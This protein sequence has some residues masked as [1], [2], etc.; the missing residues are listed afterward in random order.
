MPLT[1][2]LIRAIGLA[3]KVA[4]TAGTILAP[5]PEI[6]ARIE[7]LA[8]TVGPHGVDAFGFDPQ[9]VKKVVGLPLWLYRNYFRVQVK[10]VEHIPDGPCFVVANHS[11]QLPFD[12]AMLMTAAFL[13]REP[14]RY[15]RA[16]L[17]KFV[18]STP[19]VSVFLS[20]CGQVLGTP[21]NCRRLLAAGEAILVFPEGVRGLNKIW[22][23]RYRL[24][25]FGKGFMR[26]AIETAAPIVPAV[27]IGAEEQAPAF[28]KLERLGDLLGLPAVP[29]TPFHPMLPL[30]GLWPLPTRYRIE[31][32]EPV[33]FFGDAA[34][35]DAV[36][37]RVEEL[38][39][40][41]QE[42]IDAKLAAREHVFW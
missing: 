28:A 18:P 38:K 2:V 11:G 1:D 36:G 12:A 6:E 35:D 21:E 27:V 20:R 10:G 25:R 8:A 14:P 29:V 16:M 15:L 17:D 33:R 34:D 26:L 22:D 19:Y 5:G 3:G 32:K 24:Q 39:R 41:M 7:R 4:E 23:E 9:Y 13:E 40:S 30:L 42:L 37:A 31:F